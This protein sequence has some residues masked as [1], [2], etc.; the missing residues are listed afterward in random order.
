MKMTKSQVKESNSKQAQQDEPDD[1]LSR[2]Y[3]FPKALQDSY[4]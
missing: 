1:P 4:K 3:D 2:P